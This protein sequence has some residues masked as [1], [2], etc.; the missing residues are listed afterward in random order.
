MLY[1]WII[2]LIPEPVS[3]SSWYGTISY[4]TNTYTGFGQW[5]KIPLPSIATLSDPN[6]IQT[7]P[8]LE[9]T[10]LYQTVP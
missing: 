10:D 5:E 4:Y 9:W 8:E 7:E 1:S 3:V 6:Q 2:K